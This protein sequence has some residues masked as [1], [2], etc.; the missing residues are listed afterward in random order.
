MLRQILGEEQPEAIGQGPDFVRTLLDPHL[1]DGAD[2]GQYAGG[3]GAC[4]RACLDPCGV[5]GGRGADARRLDGGLSLRVGEVRKVHRHSSRRISAD[6]LSHTPP[7]T[8]YHQGPLS[9]ALSTPCTEYHGRAPV[10]PRGPV[11]FSADKPTP[12]CTTHTPLATIGR[13]SGLGILPV[14]AVDEG[15]QTGFYYTDPYQ[16]SVE[17]NV[18]NYGNEWT[19]A[20]HMKAAS[21]SLER[22][23]RMFIDPD[24][25]LAARKAGASPWELHER[26]FTGEFAPA[27]SVNPR[28]LL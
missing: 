18:N 15:L 26:A 2:V 8:I 28:T 6:L 24:K 20:E 10:D 17:L 9:R 16:N 4:C 14:M 5:N 19:A 3:E 22:P 21:S 25:M 12:R 27:K 23:R 7:T 13:E 11:T 1:A